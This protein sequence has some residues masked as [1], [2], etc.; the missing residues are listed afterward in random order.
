MRYPKFTD[1]EH[2]QNKQ[3]EVDKIIGMIISCI[4]KIHTKN[5]TIN[6]I[7]C[8]RSEL[9]DFVSNFTQEQFKKL[10]V[11]VETMPKLESKV[12]FTCSHCG[13]K[14]NFI[15]EGIKDFF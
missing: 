15:L 13:H 6:A 9:V 2:I 8:E 1:I 3:N 5:T 10:T 14:E 12:N 4:D 11:F 7:D